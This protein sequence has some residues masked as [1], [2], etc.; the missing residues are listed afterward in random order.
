M[1]VPVEGGLNYTLAPRGSVWMHIGRRVRAEDY[2][3]IRLAE[4]HYQFTYGDDGNGNKKAL[5]ALLKERWDNSQPINDIV[6]EIMVALPERDGGS[7]TVE[8][9]S[10]KSIP[11]TEAVEQPAPPKKEDYLA[12]ANYGIF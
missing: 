11:V 2:A 3:A 1:K 4:T 12:I 7:P 9:I 5:F 6:V 8:I 10:F